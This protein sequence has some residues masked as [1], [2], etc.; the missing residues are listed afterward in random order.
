MLKKRRSKNTKE[1]RLLTI[2]KLQDSKL[3]AFYTIYSTPTALIVGDSVNRILEGRRCW[4]VPLPLELAKSFK[5]DV[6]DAG[7]S[8]DINRS[9]V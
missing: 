8:L 3:K 4:R 5:A 9:F 7:I 1:I 2:G 6:I